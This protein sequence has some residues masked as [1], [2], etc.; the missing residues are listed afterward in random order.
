MKTEID[1]DKDGLM[2]APTGPGLGAD[3]DF[4]VIERNTE[5]VLR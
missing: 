1:I 2:H 3:I 5:A 4:D